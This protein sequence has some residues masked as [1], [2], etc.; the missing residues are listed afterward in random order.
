LEA[1]VDLKI[2][3]QLWDDNPQ[4]VVKNPKSSCP[5]ASVHWA[6]ESKVRICKL[7]NKFMYKENE[8]VLGEET[9]QMLLVDRHD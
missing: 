9:F 8:K 6:M 5:S 7:K 3:L 1:G 4:W 2:W